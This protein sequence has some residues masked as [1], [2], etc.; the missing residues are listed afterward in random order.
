M[1]SKELKNELTKLR[2][3]EF[4]VFSLSALT[5]YPLAVVVE[6][7]MEELCLVNDLDL[8]ELK[9][10]RFLIAIQNA[11]QELPYHNYMHGADVTQT[12]FHMCTEG[13]L[14]EALCVS[15][16]GALAMIIAAAVHDVGHPGVTGKFIVAVSDPLSITYNDQSPLE[17]MHLALAFQLW[18]ITQN[19]FTEKM[20]RLLYKDLRKMI[21]DLVLATDNDMHFGL[22]GKVTEMITSGELSSV[23]QAQMTAA[24]TTINLVPPTATGRSSLSTTGSGTG[25]SSGLP[26]TGRARLA[27]TEN[28]YSSMKRMQSERAHSPTHNMSHTNLL[29]ATGDKSAVHKLSGERP[30]GMVKKLSLLSIDCNSLSHGMNSPEGALSGGATVTTP[31][32]GT[33]TTRAARVSSIVLSN[34]ATG[35]TSAYLPMKSQQLLVLQAALHAADISGPAKPWEIH[36]KWTSLVMEE[37]YK[38]GDK[39]RELNM[40]ITYAFDRYQPVPMPKFQLGFIKAIVNPLYKI[41]TKIQ[42]FNVSVALEC[43]E[44]NTKKWESKQMIES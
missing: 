40:P 14:I 6:A 28:Q 27:S 10:R 15:N 3:W 44:K 31:R 9:L 29:V 33:V 22:V 13:A 35:E 19:N 4:N 18:N 26:I 16:L 5:P 24:S 11:Y 36:T 30:P 38:Q 32:G 43:M 21:I 37:F 41:L 1:V 12:V 17:N 23:V 20:P 8:S 42:G 25:S 39:E 2:K 34:P 7:S